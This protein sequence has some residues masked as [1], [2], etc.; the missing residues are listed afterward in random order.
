M[1]MWPA[2]TMPVSNLTFIIQVLDKQVTESQS[3][4]ALCTTLQEDLMRHKDEMDSLREA[5]AKVKQL[6]TVIQQY[7]NKLEGM[8]F[9]KRSMKELEEKNEELNKVRAN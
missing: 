7:K 3:K 2:L 6:E 4:V 5:A 9:L 8:E 1:D